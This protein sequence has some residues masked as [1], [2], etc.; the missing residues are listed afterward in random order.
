MDSFFSKHS[1]ERMVFSETIKCLEESGHEK[2]VPDWVDF[3]SEL[4]AKEERCLTNFTA[5]WFK[6]PVLIKDFEMFKGK[7]V[8]D[9]GGMCGL[10]AFLA[11]HV[12]KAESVNVVEY[13]KDYCDPCINL[14]KNSSKGNITVH[15]KTFL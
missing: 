8:V 11:Y 2:L 4:F 9:V 5:F 15:Q 3:C 12:G 10:S 14:L 6:F 13:N 1:S 7:E